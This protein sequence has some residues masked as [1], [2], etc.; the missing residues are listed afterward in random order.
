[1]VQ[2][3]QAWVDGVPD[4]M[5]S[6][7]V[8]VQTEEKFYKTNIS[9]FISDWDAMDKCHDSVTGLLGVE[10]E[11]GGD[12]RDKKKEQEVPKPDKSV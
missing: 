5:V 8:Q 4:I 1:M 11:G 10:L 2:D 9:K 3:E 6:G 12:Q 7:P